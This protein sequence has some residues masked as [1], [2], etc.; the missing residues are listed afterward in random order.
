MPGTAGDLDIRPIDATDAERLRT[1]F[2]GVP[3]GDR[4]FFREDVLEPATIERWLADASSRRLVAVDG[5]EI[6]G[7]AAVLPG[8]GWSQHVGEVRL[9][10]GPAHRGRGL[11]RALARAA[12]LGV[13]DLGLTK[14]VVEVVADDDPTVN[15]FTTL[16]FEAEGLLRDHVRSRA[17][18]VHDLL[19]LSHFVDALWS[20][21]TT[22]GVGEALGVGDA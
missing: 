18:E 17:G 5:D 12:L 9:V 19:I 6:A 20:T 22:T 14:L 4:T 16:G 7:Y 21:M 3:E 11:G 10:V 13:G 1:F 2:A 15:M 8:V